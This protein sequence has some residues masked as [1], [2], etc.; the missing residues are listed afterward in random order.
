MI[1]PPGWDSK[2]SKYIF[3][4]GPLIFF[5][6]LFVCFCFIVVVFRIYPP[7]HFRRKYDIDEVGYVDEV[8]MIPYANII[9][10][11]ILCADSQ[12]GQGKEPFNASNIGGFLIGYIRTCV[13]SGLSL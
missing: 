5:V 6:C 1:M 10:C 12:A 3:W 13:C 4:T 11:I 8:S 7:E 9:T 2:F